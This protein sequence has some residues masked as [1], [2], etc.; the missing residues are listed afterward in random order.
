M[1]KLLFQGEVEKP[2]EFSAEDLA[3]LAGQVPDVS[4]LVPGRE[5]TGIRFSFLLEWV[6]PKKTA[7][8]VTLASSDGDFSANIPLEAVR[9]AV[10]V[11][12]LSGGPLSEK[13]GGPFRFYIPNAAE[14]GVPGVDNCANVK[15]LETVR[16]TA[17]AEKDTRPPSKREHEELHKKSG[18]EHSK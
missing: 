14:C 7:T 18:H 4:E 5:G 15:F 10:V 16:L 6:K 9:E 1:Q 13:K 11:Y 3:K 8:H 2:A 17:G 12:G